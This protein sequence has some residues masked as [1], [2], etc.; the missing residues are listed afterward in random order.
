[1]KNIIEKLNIARGIER[2]R[3]DKISMRILW[4]ESLIFAGIYGMMFRSLLVGGMIFLCLT[5]LMLKPKTQVYTIYI[6]SFLWSFVF[7]A[8]GFGMA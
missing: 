5:L 6:L 4:V 1:M 8:I 7:A 2:V 3:F